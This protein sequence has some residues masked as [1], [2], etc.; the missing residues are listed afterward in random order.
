M[1]RKEM[2]AVR[3]HGAPRL[4][5]KAKH[6]TEIGVE[7]V[8]GR[9]TAVS[10]DARPVLDDGRVLDVANVIWCTGFGKDLRWI[11]FPVAGE[12]GWPEQRRG[13]V[14][15]SPGLYFVGLPFLQ[16]FG[17]MLVGGVGRDAARVARHIAATPVG[18]PG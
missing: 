12:D 11:G 7:V 1:G 15:S 8:D 18:R 17:S 2:Q 3:H 10:A 5:V 6:L 13:V 14:E 9:V 4:R 16:A